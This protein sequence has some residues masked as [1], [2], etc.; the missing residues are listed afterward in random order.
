MH[1]L[2][3]D[4]AVNNLHAFCTPFVPARVPFWSS[5]DLSAPAA[6]TNQRAEGWRICVAF[7]AWIDGGCDRVGPVTPT[8]AR[9][10]ADSQAIDNRG[11]FR[12]PKAEDPC[13]RLKTAVPRDRVAG[14]APMDVEAVGVRR[15]AAATARSPAAF[16]Q[17]SA[18]LVMLSPG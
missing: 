4:Q 1:G 16:F 8:R 12:L 13:R 9:S 14:L 17:P 6:P 7:R 2:G 10:W 11:V 3:R 15:L 18:I 5:N